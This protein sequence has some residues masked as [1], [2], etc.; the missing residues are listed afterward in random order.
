MKGVKVI[1]EGIGIY[2]FCFENRIREALGRDAPG[3]EVRLQYP[4]Q[5]SAE[6]GKNPHKHNIL[7]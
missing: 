1:R 4:R 5:H 6:Y 3:A 7:T 2:R